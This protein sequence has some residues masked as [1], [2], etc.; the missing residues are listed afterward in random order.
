VILRGYVPCGE[1]AAYVPLP[2]GCEHYRPNRKS[3]HSG[4]ESRRRRAARE[5]AEVDSFAAMMGAR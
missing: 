1:C 3:K 5:R 2:G 4:A